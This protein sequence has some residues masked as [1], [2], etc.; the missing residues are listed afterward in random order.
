MNNW[1]KIGLPIVLAVLLVLTAVS[2]TLAITS[3]GN[4]KQTIAYQNPAGVQYV[5][6]PYCYGYGLR[7][8]AGNQSQNEPATGYGPGRCF[9]W[10]WN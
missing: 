6:G 10:R 3:G 2:L 7:T 9:G 5:N 4:G 1:L 8:A